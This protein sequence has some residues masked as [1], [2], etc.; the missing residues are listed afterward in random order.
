VPAP[1]LSFRQKG[2]NIFSRSDGRDARAMID[3]FTCVRRKDANLG[4][5]AFRLRSK[6]L[7][8]KI[9]DRAFERPSGA[10]YFGWRFRLVERY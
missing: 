7:V 1:S 6:R 3:H 2:S 9:G 5:G 10:L 8:E 4:G